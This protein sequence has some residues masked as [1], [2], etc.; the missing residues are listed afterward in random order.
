MG[1]MLI[2]FSSRDSQ[3]QIS[4]LAGSLDEGVSLTSK[5]SEPALVY[6]RTPPT[7]ETKQPQSPQSTQ[8]KP[9]HTPTFLY[10]C[11][12]NQLYRVNLH[13]RTVQA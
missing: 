10:S 1:A 9:Q 12:N 5:A 13:W 8:T 2:C 4:E 6:H 3:S 11:D 7:E